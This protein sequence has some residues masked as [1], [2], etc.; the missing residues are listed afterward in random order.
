MIIISIII[1]TKKKK[2]NFFKVF[3]KPGQTVEKGEPLI[4][5]EAMKMEVN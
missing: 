5:L 3:V 1:T 4:V 2:K